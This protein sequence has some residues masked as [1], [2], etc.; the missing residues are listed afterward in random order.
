MWKTLLCAQTGGGAGIKGRKRKPATHILS[1]SGLSPGELLGSFMLFLLQWSEAS[2]VV[3]QN[4][5]LV[6]KLF[7]S[8]I[9]PWQQF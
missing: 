1:A 8:G 9:S 7:F 3:N 5:F 4:R 2:E 6:I